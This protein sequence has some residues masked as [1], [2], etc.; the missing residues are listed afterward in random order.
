[1]AGGDETVTLEVVVDK[2]EEIRALKEHVRV[3]TIARDEAST[4]R[5]T[6]SKA[7]WK[8]AEQRSKE[9]GVWIVGMISVAD[10]V[11]Q[12]AQKIDKL[13]EDNRGE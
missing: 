3:L 13:I 10:D 7:L 5:E 8:L 1:M 6:G 11:E 4:A 12:L 9:R 2:D